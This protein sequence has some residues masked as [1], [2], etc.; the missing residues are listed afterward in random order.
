VE[1]GFAADT[2]QMDRDVVIDIDYTH[3]AGQRGYRCSLDGETFAQVDLSLPAQD[4]VDRDHEIV[5]VVDCSYSMVGSSI[6]QAR[7]ALAIMLRSL[8][9]QP[10]ST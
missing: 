1:V 9:E 7:Q 8:P 5:F 3:E 10:G 4:A 6:E 2:V